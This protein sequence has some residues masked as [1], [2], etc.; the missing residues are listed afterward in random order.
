MTVEVFFLAAQVPSWFAQLLHPAFPSVPSIKGL[1]QGQM[2]IGVVSAIFLIGVVVRALFNRA[3]VQPPRPDPDDRTDTEGSAPHPPLRPHHGSDPDLRLMRVPL[4][5]LHPPSWPMVLAGFH[6]IRGSVVVTW[7]AFPLFARFVDRYY[8]A[9]ISTAFLGI[10]TGWGPIGMV[11]LRRFTDEEGPVPPI[12]V[13]L[14]L[15]A[16]F[17][18]PWMVIGRSSL[19]IHLFG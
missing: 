4:C 2:M 13:I 11:Y 19:M 6:S 16:F 17:V 10:T 7:L 15:N 14:P 9:V 1:A 8:A 3:S 5:N 18:I 12:P